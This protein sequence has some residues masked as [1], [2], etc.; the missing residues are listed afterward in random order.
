MAVSY[1][2]MIEAAKTLTKEGLTMAGTGHDR[3][4]DSA[5]T[6]EID[7]AEPGQRQRQLSR[8]KPEAL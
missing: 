4:T 3:R 1:G 7:A 8:R 6:D 5:A 2:L